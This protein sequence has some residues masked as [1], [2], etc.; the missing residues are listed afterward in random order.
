MFDD[1]KK[2]YNRETP[3]AFR[4]LNHSL[5][6]QKH[7][8]IKHYWIKLQHKCRCVFG[9][10]QPIAANAFTRLVLRC[11][12]KTFFCGKC[13][14]I[15]HTH[16]YTHSWKRDSVRMSGK[17][18]ASH[19]RGGA[20]RCDWCFVGFSSAHC[21]SAVYD[22]GV[23]QMNTFRL[24]GW[25]H[26]MEVYSVLGHCE[27][28][29]KHARQ[30]CARCEHGIINENNNNNN[31]NRLSRQAGDTNFLR[32]LNNVWRVEELK[33][34][35]GDFMHM[36]FGQPTN[37]RWTVWAVQNYRYFNKMTC[38]LIEVNS[39]WQIS[40][41]I[42]EM[43]FFLCSSNKQVVGSWCIAHKKHIFICLLIRI[44]LTNSVACVGVRVWSRFR[45]S[46]ILPSRCFTHNHI[47]MG[48]ICLEGQKQISRNSAK[49]VRL[50]WNTILVNNTETDYKT[51][52]KIN[53]STVLE[54]CAMLVLLS[55]LSTRTPE[56][57]AL[58][59]G[60]VPIVWLA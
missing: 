35:R 5:L 31:S 39:I 29:G 59:V 51:T 20:V 55:L 3:Y 43:L 26:S 41:E 33:S 48:G 16:Q 15:R 60:I 12:P 40:C 54:L 17:Y 22:D 8:W 18:V 28:C 56:Y 6:W 52:G 46:T 11:A 13:L 27:Q 19:T 50:K 37:R 45:G 4:S 21:L 7:T 36:H 42:G 57:D 58:R 24:T 32:F 25:S 30:T 38:A 34:H 9:L 10:L 44:D 47:L 53:P 14:P 1:W 2:P 23:E 49:L